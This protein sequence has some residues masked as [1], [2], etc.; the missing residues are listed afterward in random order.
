MIR[1]RSLEDAIAIRS[2]DLARPLPSHLDVAHATQ[3]RVAVCRATRYVGSVRISNGHRSVS[4]SELCDAIASQ[5]GPGLLAS[6]DGASETLLNASESAP[7]ADAWHRLAHPVLP[8]DP[9]EAPA[10]LPRDVPVSI[11]VCTYDRPDDLRRCLL[12]LNEQIAAACRPVEAVVVDNHPDSGKTP[13]VV[14]GFPNVWLVSEPRAGLAYARNAGFAAARGE[15]CVM[16]DDDVTFPKG[17]L[18]HLVA[19]FARHDVAMVTG[20][21]LPI[22]LDTP[23]QQLFEEYGGLGRGAERRVFDRAWLDAHRR[24]AAPMWSLG[25]TANAAIRC[26]VFADGTIQGMHEA[27]GPGTP[28]GVGED[29]YL[30]YELLREGHAIVY[31]PAAYV[32]HRHR[33]TRAALRRQIYNYSKG[34][35]AYHLVTL[36]EDGDLRGLTRCL[37]ELPQAHMHRTAARLRGHTAYPL[38]LLL[39]ELLGN[40]AGPLALWRSY[41]RVRRLG[42]SQM[43]TPSLS[44]SSASSSV[45]S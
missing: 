22:A 11:V 41:R 21:V 31:E 8:T 19:P 4:R 20:N 44:P 13:P 26:S 27:L 39:V 40:L 35:V 24:R 18:E 42:R 1:F 43:R 12:S 25:A 29:T 14:D 23:A 2:V 45:Q 15:I 5:L 33:Q 32:W 17:W 28:T 10:T 38:S 7:P 34:H 37:L 9:P 16:T 3:T 30:F 36:L 6:S